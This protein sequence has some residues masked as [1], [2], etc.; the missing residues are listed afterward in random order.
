MLRGASAHTVVLAL[1]AV[2]A[3][4]LRRTPELIVVLSGDALLTVSFCRAPELVVVL[5]LDAVRAGGSPLLIVVLSGGAVR[6]LAGAPDPVGPGGA[7]CG[8]RDRALDID[9]HEHGGLVGGAVDPQWRAE[10]GL[11][12]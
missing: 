9:T 8:T 3:G 10:G 6:A 11:V 2:R 7:A 12:V 4:F 5:A 1:G